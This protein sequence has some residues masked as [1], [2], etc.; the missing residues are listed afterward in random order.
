MGSTSDEIEHHIEST[1]E[2][3]RS[4]LNELEGRVK[5]VADWRQHYRNNPGVALSIAFGAG[6]LLAGL[7]GGSR[8]RGNGYHAP[9]PLRAAS[10][11]HI[12]RAWDNIQSALVGIAA[13]RLAEGLA[14]AVANLAE[15]FAGQG[16]PH[17]SREYSGNGVQGEGNYRAARRYRTAA[18]RFAHRAD[19]ERAARQ[20]A[21]RSEV[22]AQ[23]MAEAEAAGRS[24]AKPS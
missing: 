13:S 1:R 7:L 21:P 2:D 24:R 12:L 4:N 9:A 15:H 3:L 8:V 18:E 16:T 20:A 11:G 10:G 23:D 17:A 22:E 14:R 5:S 6:L 19:V